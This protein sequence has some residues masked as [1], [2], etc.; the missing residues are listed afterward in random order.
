[1]WEWIEPRNEYRYTSSLLSNTFFSASVSLDRPKRK[2]PSAFICTRKVG[3]HLHIDQIRFQ[4]EGWM[5]AERG[6]ECLNTLFHL[7]TPT[8]SRRVW[9]PR[10]RSQINQRE[11]KRELRD[12]GKERIFAS[13]IVAPLL[14][15]VW[16]RSLY[17]YIYTERKKERDTTLYKRALPYPLPFFLS[18][19]STDGKSCQVR[20]SGS[21]SRWLWDGEKDTRLSLSLISMPS[22]SSACSTTPS[23]IPLLSS[24]AQ[25]L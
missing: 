2:H 21:H 6:V 24:V 13:Y 16:T 4:R 14:L 3:A 1:M 5:L 23:T 11:K 9:K 20:S 25:F 7:W 15:T 22:C 18:L 12:S 8:D 10:K 19:L 17:I